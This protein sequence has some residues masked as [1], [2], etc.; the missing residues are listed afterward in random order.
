MPEFQSSNPAP[1]SGV[2]VNSVVSKGRSWSAAGHWFP[3]SIA[4]VA[5]AL[6]VCAALTSREARS[7]VQQKSAV[8]A[9]NL[10]QTQSDLEKLHRQKN[11]SDAEFR[12]QIESQS[13]LLVEREERL[14]GMARDAEATRA[15]MVT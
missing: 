1:P 4:I 10:R 8:L 12:R 14:K 5:V 6:S 7:I 11:A 2:N 3:H 15:E 9:L 13:A